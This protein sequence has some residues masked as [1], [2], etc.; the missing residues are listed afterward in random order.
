MH[1]KWGGVPRSSRFQL[2]CK[3]L[4]ERTE[5]ELSAIYARDCI[6]YGI[7]FTVYYMGYR[8]MKVMSNC[9][10]SYH[11]FFKSVFTGNKQ[12]TQ[13]GILLSQATIF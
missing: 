4:F 5:K 8:F 6:L 7:S 10:V 9:L 1:L 2:C 3:P 12:Q 11:N 13:R